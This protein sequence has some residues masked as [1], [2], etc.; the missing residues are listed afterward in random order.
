MMRPR[1]VQAWLPERLP[2]PNQAQLCCALPRLSHVGN[3]PAGTSQG[4]PTS[5]RV[6][7]GDLA[8]HAGAIASSRQLLAWI[9]SVAAFL[10]GLLQKFKTQRSLKLCVEQGEMWG[11][12]GGA[13][14]PRVG[15]RVSRPQE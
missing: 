12:S 15:V 10:A 1:T 6:N 13:Y 2:G 11:L 4:Y 9:G 7:A 3:T 8:Y 14:L 5:V